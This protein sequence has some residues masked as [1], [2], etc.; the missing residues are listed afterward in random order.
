MCQYARA[1][2]HFLSSSSFS[3]LPRVPYPRPNATNSSYRSL[4]RDAHTSSVSPHFAL[5]EPS[6][7]S[8]GH[9]STWWQLLSSPS[10]SLSRFLFSSRICALIGEASVNYVHIYIWLLLLPLLLAV[11]W[12]EEIYLLRRGLRV[13][14]NSHDR[15]ILLARADIKSAVVFVFVGG[16]F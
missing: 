2:A 10:L 1:R 15:I 13:I 8:T 11:G 4:D 16:R 6:R 3:S 12:C 14:A 5:S 7:K 9:T